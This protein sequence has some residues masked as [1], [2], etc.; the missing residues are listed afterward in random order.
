MAQA[1]SL[2]RAP[3]VTVIAGDA[4]GKK[5]RTVSFWREVGEFTSMSPVRRREALF[6]MLFVAPWLIGFIVFTLGPMLFSAYASFTDYNLIRPPQW[7]GLDNYE[8][9]FTSDRFFARAMEN[10]FWMVG[11]K[12][13][14]M[15]LLALALAVLLHRRL[16]GANLFRTIVYLPN[17]LSGVAAIFLWRWILAPEG[18]LNSGLETLGVDGPSWFSDPVWTKPGLVLMGTWW[19]GGSV[20]IFLAGLNSIPRQLYEAAEVD[21]ANE[22]NKLWGI[23]LPL[24]SPTIF[25]ITITS[26][27]GTFQMFTTA[28]I[29]INPSDATIGGPGGSLLFYVLYIY[30][31]AFGVMGRGGVD[32]GYASALAWILFII[33]MIIT[34]VQLRLSR[35]WVYYE[36]D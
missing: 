25:F 31:R 34:F 2:K 29:I 30:N 28:F 5:K 4:P 16:V 10:T 14:L 1:E 8:A 23:T 20:L 18:L 3:Q 9:I 12:T 21:G 32:M 24:L 11:I 19:V 6:G 26:I 7:S 22:W 15:I 35:R 33:I 17:V 13:P 36:T 27:I